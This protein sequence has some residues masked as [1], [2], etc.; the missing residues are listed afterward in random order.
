MDNMKLSV[1]LILS[2]AVLP[3][4]AAKQPYERYQSIVDRQ[5]FGPLP[6][7]FD[8][9]KLPSE[10][11]RTTAADEKQLTQE[12]EK[13]QSSIHFSAINVTPEG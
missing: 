1:G 11:T 6:P 10:V 3:L 9:T 12:Q 8:P 13:L 4:L 7:G 2:L 5:M